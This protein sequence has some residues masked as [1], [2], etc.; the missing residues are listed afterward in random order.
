MKS[1]ADWQTH[2]A[3]VDGYRATALALIARFNDEHTRHART[4]W[5]AY[6][7]CV[8]LSDWRNG[9][10]AAASVLFGPRAEEKARAYSAAIESIGV[11]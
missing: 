3:R 10:G 2:C 6:N 11:N 7:G 8:E 5:A 9:R 1:R 4:V